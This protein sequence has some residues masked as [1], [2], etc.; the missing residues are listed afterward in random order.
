VSNLHR[1]GPLWATF[2]LKNPRFLLISAGFK[3]RWGRHSFFAIT[4]VLTNGFANT[5][6]V[7]MGFLRSQ[8][9]WQSTSPWPKHAEQ[10][11]RCEAESHQG[12]VSVDCSCSHQTATRGLRICKHLAIVI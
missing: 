5:R 8:S 11:N 1:N 7:F 10:T 2:G 3:S 4:L 9:Q 6:L 12:C